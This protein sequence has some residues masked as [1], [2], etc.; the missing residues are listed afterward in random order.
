MEEL[1]TTGIEDYRKRTQ[2]TKLVA[3]P[4]GAKF[5]IKKVTGRDFLRQGTIPV[6]G[7]RELMESEEHRKAWWDRLS[8]DQK[9]KQME[10]LDKMLSLAVVSPELSTE[11][12][13]GALL[14]NELT[15]D[16]Y[17]ALLSEITTFSFGR[18]E[19]F[20]PFRPQPDTPLDRP[21]R[22]EI[23]PASASNS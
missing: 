4:S 10:T 18:G 3:L 23:P 15:D 19:S 8:D 20:K 17:Y 21:A 11:P 14:V 9:K 12:R 1:K 6:Q 7:T 22:P 13:E 5:E 16:D 2:A